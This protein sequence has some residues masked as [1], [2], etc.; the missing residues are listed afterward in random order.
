MASA[1]TLS[2]IGNW[3]S[4]VALSFAMQLT[5]AIAEDNPIDAAIASERSPADRA[6]DAWRKPR[7]VLTFMEVAPDQ[8]VLDFYAGPG[9]Y[10]EL[11]SRVVGPTGSVLV[12]NNELYAQ[13][14]YSGL[15]KRLG[16]N[17]L[18]N[19]KMLKEASNYLTLEPASLDRVLFVQ[20]Y[21]DLY[22]QPG[23]SP[24]PMGDPKK[25]LA[26]LFAA[27]QP[28]GLVVVVDH[29]ASIA[30]TLEPC[31][32]ILSKRVLSLLEKAMRL[33]I[34]TTITRCRFSIP[35]SVAKLISSSTNFAD[36]RAT[37][38]NRTEFNRQQGGS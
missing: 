28:N 24:E 35:Q 27:L 10:S 12:Y 25:V 1:Q 29:V 16:R 11:L 13:A 8:R 7:E 26:I 23:G 38:P 5:D 4:M 30:L 2:R 33:R 22:W 34:L 36:R 14:A 19:T 15:M 18:P 32:Q 31:A 37:A 20:V 21:H 3:M 9:Y 17:R 6:E